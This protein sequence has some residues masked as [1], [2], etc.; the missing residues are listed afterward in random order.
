VG[1]CE[2]RQPD[3]KEEVKAKS[4][5]EVGGGKTTGA[6]RQPAGKQEANMKGRGCTGE[7]SRPKAK[8]KGLV[9]RTQEK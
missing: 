1:H 2:L 7:F 9:P 4:R 6:T 5:G 3:G 8:K